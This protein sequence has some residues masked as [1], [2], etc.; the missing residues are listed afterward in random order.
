MKYVALLLILLPLHVF[1]ME[2]TPVDGSSGKK[3]K[4]LARNV[5]ELERE[6]VTSPQYE[7]FFIRADDN[8]IKAFSPRIKVTVYSKN[9]DQETAA[10]A[11][12][13]QLR[14]NILLTIFTP[15]DNDPRTRFTIDI[16]SNN[17]G[18]QRPIYPMYFE[19]IKHMLKKHFEEVIIDHPDYAASPFASK[20]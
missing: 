7:E 14:K 6:L 3:R 11:L 9:R 16:D 1:C 18:E 12:S 17:S 8:K 5:P 19:L 13:T 10:L 4:E 20:Q 15:S 2:S